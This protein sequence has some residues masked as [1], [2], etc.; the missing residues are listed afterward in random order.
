MLELASWRF[1]LFFLTLVLSWLKLL[2]G[3]MGVDCRRNIIQKGVISEHSCCRMRDDSTSC[4]IFLMLSL[5][6]CS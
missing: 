6:E 3:L 5:E 4:S 1:P 2:C